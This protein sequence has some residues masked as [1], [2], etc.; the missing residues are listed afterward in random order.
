M[1]APAVK[2]PAVEAH[3]VE[4]ETQALACAVPL[5]P[6]STTGTIISTDTKSKLVSVVERF[7]IQS[8]Q[9][10]ISLDPHHCSLYC[11]SGPLAA[12]ASC[13]PRGHRQSQLMQM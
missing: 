7:S 9:I 5:L 4:L 1:K 2:A 13:G 10:P 3:V 11:K 8:V 12:A 6:P